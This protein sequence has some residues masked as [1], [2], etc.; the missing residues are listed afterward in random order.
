MNGTAAACERFFR[1]YH[2][3]CVSPDR[4][5][6]FNY[7]NSVHSLNDKLNLNH[8]ENFFEIEE[9][10]ALKALRNLYHHQEELIN[11]LKIIPVQELPPITTDLLYLCLVPRA[12]IEASIENIS[13]R[14][15]KDQEKMIRSIL[16]WHGEVVNINPCIFNFSV[17][18]FEKICDLGMDVSGE[19]FEEFKASYAYENEWGHSH[20]VTGEIGCHSGSVDDVLRV[21]YGN[22]T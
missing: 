6:L 19:E 22:V 13:A 9:F 16:G 7:L 11:E 18:V 20:F 14:Y 3:H 10:V 1:L 17:K 21:A 8:Q 4:D 15:R 12:L 2:K 5:T